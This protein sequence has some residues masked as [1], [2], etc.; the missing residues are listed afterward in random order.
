[1]LALLP[2]KK[3]LVVGVLMAR[4]AI[5][6]VDVCDNVSCNFDQYCAE[7]SDGAA[8]C[9]AKP[10][11]GPVDAGAVVDAGRVEQQD[12]GHAVDAG[13]A[14][15]AGVVVSDPT[16]YI[17]LEYDYPTCCVGMQCTCAA[18]TVDHCSLTQ[19]AKSSAFAASR[20]HE[21]GGCAV[22]QTAT[23]AYSVVCGTCTLV[24]RVCRVNGV[25]HP[26]KMAQCQTTL[27]RSYCGWV[28]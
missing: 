11:S 12:A 10:V 27:N 22:T 9:V 18:C 8:H 20:T 14:F 23:D 15:D 21:F 26:D 3:L 6:P 25:D 16:V 2:M 4:C 24:D 7:G 17:T 5:A 19:G 13:H 28:N 1:M